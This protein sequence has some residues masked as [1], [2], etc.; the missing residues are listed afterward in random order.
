MPSYHLIL[1]NLISLNNYRLIKF[2]YL[3]IFIVN[4]SDDEPSYGKRKSKRDKWM[5][6]R[7]RVYKRGGKERSMN[8]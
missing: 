2:I 1:I 6:R 8:Y 4:M 3:L 7:S 5:K